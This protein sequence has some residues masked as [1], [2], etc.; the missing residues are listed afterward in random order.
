MLWRA[1]HGTAAILFTAVILVSCGNIAGD[2]IFNYAVP[3]DRAAVS[4]L[5]PVP[6]RRQYA[7]GAGFNKNRDLSVLAVYYNGETEFVPIKDVTIGIEEN[8]G[9]VYAAPDTYIFDT[10][11]EKVVNV[12]YANRRAYYAV[13]VGSPGSGA[14]SGDTSIEIIIK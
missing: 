9:E 5:I 10:P 11:G 2:G 1:G 12:I 8:P 4:A 7:V 3:P 14:G 13:W 6:I